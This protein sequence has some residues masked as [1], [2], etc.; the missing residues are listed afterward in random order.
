MP[1]KNSV[2]LQPL[3]VANVREINAWPPYEGAFRPLD[4]ALRSG[5]WLDTLPE[6]SS[7]CRFAA[8]LDGR[9]AGFSILTDITSE[10]AEIYLAVRADLTG[11]GVGRQILE[12]T[13]ARAF[14]EMKLIRVYL[15]VRVWH[16]HA[17][18]LY[19][20]AGFVTTGQ[21]QEEVAGEMVDFQIMELQASH[22]K[23]AALA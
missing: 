20:K 9:L 2:S 12:L 13:L 6:S 1:V 8:L 11:H 21:K 22:F 17:I 15:K 7:T 23:P 18:A 3:N 4:Y 14:F 5:G 10:A 19:E 16:K